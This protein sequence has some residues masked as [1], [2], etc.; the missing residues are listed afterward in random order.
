MIETDVCII[1]AGPGGAMTALR[2]GKNNIPFVIIDKAEFPRDKVCGDG[3][4][5]KVHLMLKRI[6]PDLFDRFVEKAKPMRSRG[7]RLFLINDQPL[8]L[9]FD[10]GTEEERKL[11]K[12]HTLKRKEFDA[13]MIEEVSKLDTGKIIL[14]KAVN[15]TRKLKDAYLVEADGVQ[16]KSK[17]VIDASG[18]TAKI[19]GDIHKPVSADKRTAVAV[20]TYYEGVTGCHKD[21]YIELYFTEKVIPGY[22]WI[23]PLP[24]GQVNVG[25][26]MLKSE[27]S[28]RKLKLGKLMDDL[29]Q[30]HPLLAER[31]QS[32]KQLDK[33]GA[34]RLPLGF[35]TF[36]VSGDRYMQVGDAAHLIDPFTGEG[37]GNAV[38]SG[39]YAA[40]QAIECLVNDRFDAKFMKAYDKRLKRVMGND[41]F[42]SRKLQRLMF[43]PKLTRWLTKR[44]L[45]NKH[46]AQIGSSLFIDESYRNKLKNPIFGLKILFN[47]R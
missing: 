35:P 41:F 42:L 38:Y 14:G 12:L 2:L 16:I 21:D 13:F 18:A 25:L 29:I 10:I 26:G 19:D 36:G 6:S 17:I 37:V 11:S 39:Y 24:N 5:G 4:T 31:F 1:G 7:A 28:K 46:M 22:F 3:L 47:I 30:T 32:A 8:D 9:C 43:Y 20:R 45:A 15:S 23:F 34:H 33:L 27:V 44:I 40:E